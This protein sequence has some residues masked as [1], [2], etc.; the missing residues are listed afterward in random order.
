M[1]IR[2][3]FCTKPAHHQGLGHR[4][5]T[6]GSSASHNPGLQL[7]FR[8]RLETLR[9]GHWEQEV[10]NQYAE[11]IGS[12]KKYA[13]EIFSKDLLTPHQAY[14]SRNTMQLIRLRRYVLAARR[15]WKRKELDAFDNLCKFLPS[16]LDTYSNEGDP[17]H[18]QAQ[19]LEFAAQLDSFMVVTQSILSDRLEKEKAERLESFADQIGEA[20][21]AGDNRRAWQAANKLLRSAG[22]QHPRHTGGSF[23]PYRVDNNG[24][25]ICSDEAMGH[26]R[27]KVYSKLEDAR[28]LD[29]ASY[30]DEFIKFPSTALDDIPLHIE[31]V[32]SL[33]L[34]ER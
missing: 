1:C 29:A 13:K 28:I 8:R 27:M 31:H 18:P 2:D 15:K 16:Q 25:V 30:V 3:R 10:N 11:V 33:H 32:P 7:E 14:I 23:L 20:T 24:A 22:R 26:N 17:W 9:P 34:V 5:A 19:Q 21:L 12:I 6:G 4:F